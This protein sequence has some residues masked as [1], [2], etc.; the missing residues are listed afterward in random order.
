MAVKMATGKLIETSKNRHTLTIHVG[1]KGGGKPIATA[2]IR[3]GP[4]RRA[5]RVKNTAQAILNAS[6][7]HAGRRFVGLVE[8]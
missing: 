1:E 2:E 8:E 4:R 3:G 7:D 6:T 5:G